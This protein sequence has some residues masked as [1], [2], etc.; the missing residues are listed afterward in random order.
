MQVNLRAPFALIQAMAAQGLAAEAGPDG[1]P[2]AAGLIVNM[3]DQK[4]LKLTPGFMAYTL[5]KSALHTLTQ[6]AAQA[7]APA[8]RVNAIAPGPTLKAARQSQSHF[9]RQRAATIL[10]R[11]ADPGEICAALAYLL[12]APSVTGQVIAVDGGQHLAWRT[13]DIL[14]SA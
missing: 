9:D 8:I 6:T 5:A 14:G 12:A 1:Q 13:P 2:R 7:L 3:L 10:G 11:G 4:V